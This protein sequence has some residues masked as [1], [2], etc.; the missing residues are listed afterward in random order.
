MS[1]PFRITPAIDKLL[2]GSEDMP[3]GLYQL[4]IATIEQLTRLHYSTKSSKW[5]GKHLKALADNG[6]VQADMK[7][8]KGPRGPNFYTLTN[9]GLRNLA[10]LHVDVREARVDGTLK[11]YLL[12]DHML[13]LNDLLIAAALLKR[14]RASIYLH[15]FMHEQVLKR[16]PYKST[17][18]DKAGKTQTYTIIPAALLTFCVRQQSGQSEYRRVLLEH[19][20]ELLEEEHH[21]RRRIRAYISL[22]NRQKPMPVAFTTFKGSQRLGQMRK[23]TWQELHATQ[24]PVGLGSL[25]R[26]GSFTR[27]LEPCDVWVEPI[28]YTP[29]DEHEPRAL[30]GEG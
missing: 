13:E 6:Y 23:W 27:P 15:S 14:F 20:H 30:L 17:W 8:T 11:H 2:R 7:P 10:S 22:L 26:F 25:F 5:V 4:H 19:D 3:V 9:R 29:Y 18:Q 16:R 1:K 12:I 24:E 28:W 21:F